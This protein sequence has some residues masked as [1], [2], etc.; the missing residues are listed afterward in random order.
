MQTDQV[1][2]VEVDREF[3]VSKEQLYAAWTDAD[4]LKQWWKP[5][6]KLLLRVDN[7][8]QEGGK[9]AYHFEDGLTIEGSYQEVKEGDRLVYTWNWH[10]PEN[11]IHDGDY[12]LTV[13]FLE[14]GGG[15][16]LHVRQENLR[17]EHAIKPHQPGW[18]EALRDLQRF[19]Q[20]G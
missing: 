14:K 6:G 19:L 8:I 17:E 18:E 5:L 11:T 15:S 12:L 7:E 4:Q 20:K 2:H 9:V 13:S 16:Q 10:V 1:V 3:L